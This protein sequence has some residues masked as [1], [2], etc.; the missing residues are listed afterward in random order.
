MTWVKLDDA[1]HR[2]PKAREAGLRGRALYIAGL[3]YCSAELTDGAIMKT[4]LPVLAAEADVKPADAR[5]LVDV[6]LWVDVGDRYVVH[7][8]L[9]WNPTAAEARERRAKRQAAGRLGGQRSVEQKRSR[10]EASGQANASANGQAKLKQSP[11]PVPVPVPVPDTSRFLEGVSTV[12][13]PP[14]KAMAAAEALHIRE[15]QAQAEWGRMWD[16]YAIKGQTVGNV[17]A[18]WRRWLTNVEPAPI[19]DYPMTT[20]GLALCATCKDWHPTDERCGVN[21]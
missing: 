13:V 18:A 2:N 5:R 19:I 17:D 1:F 9:A 12:R 8:Y 14:R 20:D 3:C 10:S 15:A 7:D 6:G 4:M 11:T 16:W 21:A